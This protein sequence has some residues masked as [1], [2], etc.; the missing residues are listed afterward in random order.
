[1]Q[2]GIQIL[3]KGNYIAEL[4]HRENLDSVN[5]VSR[6]VCPK[7][8]FYLKYIKRILD[9]AVALPACILLLPVNLVIG[10][11]TF[12]DVGNPI[13]F[14]QKRIGKDGVPFYLT[15]FR[16]MT[17]EKDKYG[18][19]LPPGERVT[20]LGAFVRKYSLDELLNFWSVLKGDM[21]L[22]GPRP[23]PMEF[24]ERFSDRHRMREAVRP[25]LECPS[26]SGKNSVRYYQEQFENDIWYV[27]HVNFF[28][29]CRLCFHL[30][31]MVF[32]S[33]ERGD[34]AKSGG[35]DFLGYN[36]EGKAF[37]MRHIPEEYEKAYREYTEYEETVR[38]R[39]NVR[40][41]ER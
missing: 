10:V 2:D 17:E 36:A 28:L 24:R 34:H 25:G 38:E 32:N 1:M 41:A 13:F 12:L 27:E 22:I 40:S 26:V 31:K 20:R 6:E 5:A 35:G 15:K 3:D 19:L 21:S 16:N 9:V 23:L 29:D 37:S 8:S 33:K 30:V 7:Q 14:R 11:L 39:K 18:N 4:V